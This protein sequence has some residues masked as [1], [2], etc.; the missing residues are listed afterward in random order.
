MPI[1]GI[2]SSIKT[3]IGRKLVKSWDTLAFSFSFSFLRN[4]NPRH[5]IFIIARWF[6]VLFNYLLPSFEHFL[7]ALFFFLFHAFPVEGHW[8]EANNHSTVYHCYLFFFLP[9]F[10]LILQLN[11]LNLGYGNWNSYSIVHLL[12]DHF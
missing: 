11:Y 7:F 2:Y 9:N 10:I 3:W 8:S 6:L 5:V 12:V 4:L 1:E